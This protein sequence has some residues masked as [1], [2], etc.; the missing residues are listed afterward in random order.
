M[1][2]LEPIIDN[3][4]KRNL[5][6]EVSKIFEENKKTMIREL[7]KKKNE[8]VAGTVLEI[9]KNISL[10]S[11]KEELIITIRKENQNVQ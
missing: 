10:E 11:F 2:D 7:E 5:T 6:E 4:I 9:S 1:I 3:A 8:I